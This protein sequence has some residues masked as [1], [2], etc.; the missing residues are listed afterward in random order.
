MFTTVP[1]ACGA[2][3]VALLAACAS[4]APASAAPDGSSLAAEIDAYV[5]ES[6]D[7]LGLAGVSVAVVRDGDVLFTEGYGHDSTGE[8]VT[9]R[10]PMM[11]AS[12]SKSTTAMTVLRLVE[13]G[14]VD[15][16]TAVVDYVP[17][18]DPVDPRAEEITVRHL[19]DQTSGMASDGV[20]SPERR[21]VASLEEMASILGAKELATD[22]GA[23]HEY[24]NGNYW[25]AARVVEATT[26]EEYADVLQGEVLDPLGM[27]DSASARDGATGVEQ[28]EGVVDGHV[29]TYGFSVPRDEPADFATGA[30]G[31]V[32]SAEDM[33]RWLAPFTNEGRTV[34]GE[35][36]VSAETVQEL[37]TPSDP[38]A[39]YGLGW[40]D[41]P[42][43]DRVA[44]AG[45]LLGYTTYQ[46]V[47][48]DGVGV[49]VLNNSLTMYETPQPIAVGILDIVDGG[50]PDPP[51]PYHHYVDY[52]VAALTLL[53]LALG[54]RRLVR[55]EEWARRHGARP[56]WR[57]LLG[58][59]ARSLPFL[60]ICGY[61]VLGILARAE[62][63][64]VAGF[65]FMWPAVTIWIIAAAVANLATLVVRTVH[66]R[67]VRLAS[68]VHHP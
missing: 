53:T 34:D 43:E 25:L 32:A 10:S 38:D 17:E 3:L 54:V 50:T 19:L 42:G 37:V 41:V 68:P 46:T 16:D 22:P 58:Y 62:P 26:G 13:D 59:G 12:V 4:P 44:H 55:A 11:L 15:L 28:L 6:A 67:R 60:A 63:S 48:A 5:G 18:F 49:A 7:R 61:L 57:P 35:P 39:E 27:R 52:T 20:L 47:T 30:G 2:A 21:S 33:A 24:F 31:V 9:S 64:V 56:T 65:A 36:F 29:S 8:A 23:Q 40:R 14:L 45:T 51:T 66:L 1:R